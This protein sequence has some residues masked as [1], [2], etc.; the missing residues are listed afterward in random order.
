MAV[1]DPLQNFDLFALSMISDG[2]KIT[3]ES[4]VLGAGQLNT[5]FFRY[6]TRKKKQMGTS[7]PKLHPF[8]VC[9]DQGR[10]HQRYKDWKF[11][12]KFW[13]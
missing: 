2:W 10:A 3:G 12:Q 4:S 9:N 11:A 6:L 8:G 1:V 13:L 5:N 7:P